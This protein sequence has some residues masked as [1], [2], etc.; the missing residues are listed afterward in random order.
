MD[1]SKILSKGVMLRVSGIVQKFVKRDGLCR[2]V[3][4]TV[5][6]KVVF[7]NFLLSDS[8]LLKARKIRKGSKVDLIG[9]VTSFGLSAVCLSECY[10]DG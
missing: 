4:Q 6:K 1:D 9:K 3:V 2:L 8:V 10:L 7:S 5:T